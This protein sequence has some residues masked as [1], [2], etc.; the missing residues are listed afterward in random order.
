M[1]QG[2]KAIIICA[3]ITCAKGCWRR[4]TALDQKV[5]RQSQQFDLIFKVEIQQVAALTVSNRRIPGPLQ[6]F[7]VQ[8]KLDFMLPLDDRAYD[9]CDNLLT[10]NQRRH[11]IDKENTFLPMCL[12]SLHLMNNTKIPSRASPQN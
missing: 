6:P 2:A 11:R 9:I 4:R 10:I 7:G 5:V 12:Q 3:K 1:V 8:M